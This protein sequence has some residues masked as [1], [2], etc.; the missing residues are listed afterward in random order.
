MSSLLEDL[1]DVSRVTRGLAKLNMQPVD[2]R[3]AIEDAT[4]QVRTLV[5][6]RQHRLEVLPWQDGPWLEG[7]YK[8]L[9]QV[10][11]NLLNNAAKYTPVGGRIRLSVSVEPTTVAITVEDNGVGISQAY[12]PTIFEPFAQADRS[13]DRSQGGLGLGSREEPQCS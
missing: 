7:D 10:V 4:E 1:L 3:A 9:V 5:E 12:L 8:R 11:A 13:V 6:S 2:L